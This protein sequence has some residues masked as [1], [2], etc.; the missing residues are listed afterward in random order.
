MSWNGSQKCWRYQ[1]IFDGDS[2]GK[3]PLVV[4]IGA[5]FT[6]GSY[7]QLLYSLQILNLCAIYMFNLRT[8]L[9]GFCYACLLKTLS[10]HMDLQSHFECWQI[11]ELPNPSY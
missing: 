2:I 1:Q 9:Q 6:H 11:E 7:L 10:L 3:S 4:S 5:G 8:V